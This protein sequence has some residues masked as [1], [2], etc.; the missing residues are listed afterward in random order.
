MIVGRE[1]ILT[2]VALSESKLVSIV[3]PAGFGKT[4]VAEM[5]AADYGPLTVIGAGGT[6]DV[7]G[8]ASR[9][10]Q[11]L[12]RE[13]PQ[14]E[15]A[16]AS[17][18]FVHLQPG[19]TVA[20][21]AGFVLD[22][23]A[24]ANERDVFLFD[25]LEAIA[26]QP[27][28]LDLLVRLVK[29]AR[30]RLLLL[31]SRPPFAIVDSRMIPPN[32]HLR[33]RIDDLA[34]T[35]NEIAALFDGNL[36]AETLERVV[37]VTRGWPVAVLLLRQL[38][39]VGQLRAALDAAADARFDALDEY[40]ILEVM[41][42]IDR[43]LVDALIA[44]VATRAAGSDAVS[45][46]CAEASP[47]VLQELA[48]RLPLVRLGRD[49][50]YAVH[51]LIVSLVE[52]TRAH[53][54]AA[55]RLRAAESYERDGSPAEAARLYL[56][57]E[58][59]VAA[60][61]CLER[62]VGSAL[63]E[64]GF[65]GLDDVLD[66]IPA[67][68]LVRFP[69]LWATTETVR[70]S[71]VDLD[72]LAEE[73]FALR[74]SLRAGRD[75]LEGRQVD[76]I[77]IVLLTHL[78]QHE[79]VSQLRAEH[80]IDDESTAEGAAALAVAVLTSDMLYGRATN[81][82]ARYHRLLPS[83]RND[84]LRADFI[85]RVEA[86]MHAM[87]GRFD[88]ALRASGRALR[89]AEPTA[90]AGTLMFQTHMRAF[91]AWLAGDDAPLDAL[92]GDIAARGGALGYGRFAGLAAAWEGGDSS[93]SLGNLTPRSRAYALLL[94]A[95]RA[96]SAA[97]RTDRLLEAIRAADEA[98]D[99]WVQVLCRVAL[100]VGDGERRPM[101]LDEAL[102]LAAE[103]GQE[104]VFDSVTS[105]VHG[106]PGA[107]ALAAF[108]RRFARPA[109]AGD[110]PA[111]VRIDALS[112]TVRRGERYL[113]LSRRP[114][115][116][117]MILAVLKHVRRERLTELLWGEE[118]AD[119]G[120]HALKMVVSRAR[121]QLGDPNLIIATGGGYALSDDVVVDFERIEQLL[122]TLPAHDPLTESQRCSLREAYEAFRTFWLQNEPAAAAPAIEATVN[123]TR[124]RV[125]ERLAEDALDRGEIALAF[126]L[127]DELRRYDERDEAAHELL[128]RAYVRSGKNADAVRVYRSWS[129]HL[130][131]E[132]GAEPSFSLEDIIG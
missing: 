31:C 125:V 120:S 93:D 108:V 107:P 78:G 51:P 87:Q 56:D 79:S 15:S 97:A 71:V 115:A 92:M 96:R 46:A 54:V 103:T 84:L 52:N 72:V 88:D 25:D 112:R 57:A 129:D 64:N 132:H 44:L 101:L 36:N 126:D 43:R 117:V 77:L 60:C 4:T 119:A 47:E 76:A 66:R 53:E 42:S 10:V 17:E 70:R 5:I 62:L 75:S 121:R 2:R 21:L 68:M 100:A 26:E 28:C 3:A 59:L 18:L 23:W 69:R 58:R 83:I 48:R 105:L 7:F 14:R 38:A 61:R 106:G 102:R 127:A 19:V 113:T 55:A 6:A 110:E 29:S 91:I 123:A 122:R 27:E 82:L 128:I 89:L 65:A 20:Q 63:G 67:E 37:S 11:A 50:R 49:G 86:V 111:P 8:F 98:R 22:A 30:C 33:L 9:I 34:F 24:A 16:L 12:Q 114:L 130:R 35:P 131:D 95:G 74:N 40:L 99:R 73:G 124:Q 13:S 104:A 80:R 32:E 109:A 39:R 81:A 45:R 85:A 1:R 116:L 90:P 94:V 118:A 41:S